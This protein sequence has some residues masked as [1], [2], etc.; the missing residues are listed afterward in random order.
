MSDSDWDETL[1]RAVAARMLAGGVTFAR[2]SPPTRRARL[3]AWWRRSG[4][5][6][7]ALAVLWLSLT[8]LLLLWG[9]R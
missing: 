7:A 6:I 5:L 9:P 2:E 8:G 4:S 3:R 1:R